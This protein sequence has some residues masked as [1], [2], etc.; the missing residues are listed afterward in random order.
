MA[1]QETRIDP[2]CIEKFPTRCLHWAH[3]VL[4]AN[5]TS[6][7]QLSETLTSKSKAV[8]RHSMGCY[9][10]HHGSAEVVVSEIVKSDR[11]V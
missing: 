4:D 8:Y 1:N 5:S 7:R 9:I 10:V 6:A 3:L 11:I 2:H